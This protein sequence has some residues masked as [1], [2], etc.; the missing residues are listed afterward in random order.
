MIYIVLHIQCLLPHIIHYRPEVDLDKKVGDGGGRGELVSCPYPFIQDVL[1]LQ[2]NTESKGL[3]MKVTC[4]S[5]PPL[6]SKHQPRCDSYEASQCNAFITWFNLSHLVYT[7]CTLAIQLGCINRSK[8]LQVS[9]HIAV[10]F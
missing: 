8:T 6:L 2:C 4:K 9:I 7:A 1:C 10:V 3:E 5:T